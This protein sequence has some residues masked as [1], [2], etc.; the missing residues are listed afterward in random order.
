MQKYHRIAKCT[1]LVPVFYTYQV[2][3]RYRNW[4]S[5]TSPE[6]E[7]VHTGERTGPIFEYEVLKWFCLLAE[8]IVNPTPSR[9]TIHCI[10]R[11][12]FSDETPITSVS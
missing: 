4:V 7:C 11:H 9:S 6:T 12:T 2:S 8:L 5:Y 3:L 10:D 1:N